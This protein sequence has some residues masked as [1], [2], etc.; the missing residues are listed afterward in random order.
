MK[1]PILDFQIDRG[2]EV[3]YACVRSGGSEDAH[4]MSI[5]VR[6]VSELPADWVSAIRDHVAETGGSGG[7]MPLT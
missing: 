5:R 4:E 2:E 3:V 6:H 7:E 1:G